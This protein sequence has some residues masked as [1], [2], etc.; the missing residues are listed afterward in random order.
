[1]DRRSTPTSRL[2]LHEN[3]EIRSPHDLCYMVSIAPNFNS[4]REVQL[5]T[6]LRTYEESLALKAETSLQLI[7]G[8]AI[9][10][11]FAIAPA[12]VVSA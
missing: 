7:R 12:L 2:H 10:L 9:W 3:A 11:P 5:L 6:E 8:F 4:R 1:M